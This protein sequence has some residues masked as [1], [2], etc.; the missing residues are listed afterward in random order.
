MT[1]GR[2]SPRSSA[3]GHQPFP[4]TLSMPTP[5]T[6]GPGRSFF[7]P[8]ALAALVSLTAGVAAAGT[9]GPAPRAKLSPVER[10]TRPHLKAAHEEVERIKQSRRDLPPVPGR[11]D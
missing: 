10:M 3:I 6:P 1:D 2:Y 9:P 5:P 4:G 7:R 8:R 11:N